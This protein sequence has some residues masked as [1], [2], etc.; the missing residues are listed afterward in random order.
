MKKSNLYVMPSHI[1]NSPNSLCEAMMLGMPCISTNVGG[2]SSLLEN[3]REGVL[4]QD[5]DPWSLA[6]AIKECYLNYPKYLEYGENARKRA[7][8]RHDRKAV[9]AEL[10]NIYHQVYNK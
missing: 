4:I 5:G 8:K 1:E 7:I 9:A 6:G 10:L 2:V 3:G